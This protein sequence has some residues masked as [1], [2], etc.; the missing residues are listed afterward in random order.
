MALNDNRQRKQSYTCNFT[1]VYTQQMQ[2]MRYQLPPQ[3][4]VTNQ[5]L[6]SIHADLITQMW[7]L[8]K[9]DILHH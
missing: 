9:L 3:V 5:Q 6:E 2:V 4:T 1:V 7:L 8:D